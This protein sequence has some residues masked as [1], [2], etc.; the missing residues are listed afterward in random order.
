MANSKAINIGIP[1]AANVVLIGVSG[2]AAQISIGPLP[3]IALIVAL[4]LSATAIST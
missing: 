1:V 3:A 4:L 2:A